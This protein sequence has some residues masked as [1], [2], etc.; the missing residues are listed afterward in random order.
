MANS[1]TPD[2]NGQSLTRIQVLSAMI[3]TA[4]ILAAIA[5]IWMAFA[6]GVLFPVQLNG[7]NGL[8]GI[9][10]GLIITA[11]SGIIYRLWPLYRKS[12]DEYLELV[13]RPLVW[14]DL[15]WLGLLPGLSEEL[16]FR[17]VVLPAFG[18]GVG[19]IFISSVCFGA[20]HYSG[21]KHWPYIIWA[22]I[23]GAVLGSAAVIT[24]SLLVPV[25]AH[26]T[27]NVVSSCMWKLKH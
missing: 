6:P 21:S 20:M 17:G 26:I 22:T 9:T 8:L 2:T 3:V 18:V 25:V 14:P 5:R 23:I 24:G 27:T 7:L 13:L 1:P 10:L 15:I 4:L 11:M 16:L 12:A 19:G